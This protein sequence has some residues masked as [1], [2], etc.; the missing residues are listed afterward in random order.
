[1]PNYTVIFSNKNS[2]L[3]EKTI[4]YFNQNLN[5]LNGSNMFFDFF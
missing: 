1:M 5:S 4:E 3:N 2:E